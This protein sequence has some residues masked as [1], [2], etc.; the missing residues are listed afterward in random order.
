MLSPEK[1]S[2][3]RTAY[4]SMV[5]W[6]I[7]GVGGGWGVNRHPPSLVGESSP[8]MSLFPPFPLARPPSRSPSSPLGMSSGRDGWVGDTPCPPTEHPSTR[9][10]DPACGP[11]SIVLHSRGRWPTITAIALHPPA[12]APAHRSDTLRCM[13]RPLVARGRGVGDRL[14]VHLRFPPTPP[15]W[16]ESSWPASIP[17]S[18]ILPGKPVKPRLDEIAF[19]DIPEDFC[20]RCIRTNPLWTFF[21]F[22]FRVP[23]RRLLLP[24][25][26]SQGGGLIICDR[27]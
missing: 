25:A 8:V 24:Y 10:G 2:L 26:P 23:A 7:D 15:P 27:R 18:S 3:R 4:L 14:A 13:R 12:S 16:R 11:P 17:P 22:S 9:H 1:P 6:T 5:D 19:P 20:S 21:S